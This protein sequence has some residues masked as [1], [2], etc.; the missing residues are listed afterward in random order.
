MLDGTDF[1]TGGDGS[2]RVELADFSLSN[3]TAQQK[4][5]SIDTIKNR[6]TKHDRAA[7]V[8][9]LQEMNAR[10]ADW[11]DDDVSVVNPPPN[12]AK[13][14]KLVVLKHMFTLE[15][16]EVRIITTVNFSDCHIPSSSSINIIITHFAPFL[17]DSANIHFFYRK[18]QPYYL[19]SKR[20]SV[21]KQPAAAT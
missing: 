1:N 17:L 11:D 9:K 20:T 5:V 18:T 10:L 6:R 14:N 3:K 19:T 7:A 21:K 2:M 4:E 8:K 16:L 13:Y 12:P 15:E